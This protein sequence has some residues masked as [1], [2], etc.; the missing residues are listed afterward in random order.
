[1]LLIHVYFTLCPIDAHPPVVYCENHAHSP[2]TA[3]GDTD[4]VHLLGGDIV[5]G[6]DEDGLVR[7]KKDLELVEV[8]CLCRFEDLPSS[9]SSCFNYEYHGARHTILMDW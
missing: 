7:L 3:E 4:L 8:S 9:V 1:M 5:N 6:D 2:F